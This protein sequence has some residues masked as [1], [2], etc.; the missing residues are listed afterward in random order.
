M[1]D[2]MRRQLFGQEKGALWKSA[3]F[4][5]PGKMCDTTCTEYF[6]RFHSMLHSFRSY[7]CLPA[8]AN[9]RICSS[10]HAFIRSTNASMLASRKALKSS[11]LKERIVRMPLVMRSTSTSI[12]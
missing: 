8:G 3:R 6:T 7:W 10:D 5:Q 9:S 11:L 4:D 2:D 12:A 1:L